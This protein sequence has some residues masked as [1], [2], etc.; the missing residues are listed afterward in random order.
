MSS[1]QNRSP[2]G[3]QVTGTTSGKVTRPIDAPSLPPWLG[4]TPFAP[5][6]PDRPNTD[7]EADAPTQNVLLGDLGTREPE[8]PVDPR[9]LAR[10]LADEAKRRMSASPA[11]QP[12]PQ[13]EPSMSAED[14]RELARRLAEE[15]KRRLREVPPPVDEPL[16]ELFD[17][18]NPRS[19]GPSPGNPRSPAASMADD[20]EPWSPPD[21]DDGENLSSSMVTRPLAERATGG[22][23][24]PMSALEALAA[25]REAEKHRI[26]VSRPPPADRHEPVR[27]THSPGPGSHRPTLAPRAEPA[28]VPAQSTAP[29]AQVDAIVRE[30][31]P[32]ADLGPA[33][34]VSNV[35]VFRA[36]WR[37]HR[38]RAQHD[39]DVG[40]ITTAGV[41]LDAIERVPPGWL[42]AVKASIGIGRH[43]PETWGV[44]IDLDR[45]TVLAVARPA[46][47]YLAGI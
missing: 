15:A 47:I 39:G 8:P 46:D 45:R 10:R 13:E 11:Q 26:A 16:D 1:N 22:G 33:V 35:D 31:F 42:V 23:A 21:D 12:H 18:T 41:L 28:R 17:E 43:P 20:D 44:W 14:P 9:E 29:L 25:A 2:D 19:P 7:D 3:P 40:L 32:G 24:R 27:A 36:L 5:G 37:A 4:K 34:A 30:H 38:A 6:S